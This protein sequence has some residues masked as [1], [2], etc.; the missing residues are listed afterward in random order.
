MERPRRSAATGSSSGPYSKSLRLLWQKHNRSHWG[1]WSVKFFATSNDDDDDDCDAVCC[2]QQLLLL[3][4]LLLLLIHE[5]DFSGPSAGHR[6]SSSN[7]LRCTKRHRW[8]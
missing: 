8:P 1:D 5:N 2:R 7:F 6:V 3:L 4:L